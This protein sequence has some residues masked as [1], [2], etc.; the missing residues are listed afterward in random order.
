MSDDNYEKIDFENYLT[1]EKSSEKIEDI[2]E[3]NH[4]KEGLISKILGR[5]KKKIVDYRINNLKDAKDELSKACKDIERK[6]KEYNEKSNEL[7]ES[8]LES[9]VELELIDENLRNY[10][11]KK[12]NLES[13]I[14]SSETH[15]QELDL[16]RK[17]HK[18]NNQIR[19]GRVA[20]ASQLKK[21]K[22]EKKLYKLT[23]KFTLI[24]STM[25]ANTRSI[26]ETLD[27]QIE[28]LNYFRN[29]EK[30]QQK[31]FR[32]ST[33]GLLN[34]M[35]GIDESNELLDKILSEIE[36]LGNIGENLYL[37]ESGLEEAEDKLEKF[38]EKIT[39]N[40]EELE[41]KMNQQLEKLGIEFLENNS[42]KE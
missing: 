38:E 39:K 26:Y 1:T 21:V 32:N 18:N 31:L 25:L 16:S 29:V 36:S 15:D 3:K 27:T 40:T 6:Y 13:M 42:S 37:G 8:Y 35:K 34:G 28:Y 23:D 5:G 11:S 4:K 22:K 10:L 19:L 17:K 7:Y 24:Y 12:E 9:Q 33:K 30:P 14:N 2:I 20:R 41:E